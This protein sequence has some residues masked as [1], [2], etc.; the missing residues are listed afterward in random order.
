[1]VANTPPLPEF[2]TQRSHYQRGGEGG[3]RN[4]QKEHLGASDGRMRDGSYHF[5]VVG[6]DVGQDALNWGVH[7]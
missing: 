2:Y 4:E 3:F 7:W 6:P 5:G 1:M